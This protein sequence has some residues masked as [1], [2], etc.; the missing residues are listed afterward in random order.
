MFNLNNLFKAETQEAL[1]KMI[2]TQSDLINLYKEAAKDRD[3]LV[4]HLK[5]LVDIQEQQIDELKNDLKVMRQRLASYSDII[6]NYKDK[7]SELEE[8][9]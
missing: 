3:E 6:K 8:K 1:V 9:L 5:R 4:N 2:A 7:F